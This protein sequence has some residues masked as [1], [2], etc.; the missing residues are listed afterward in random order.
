M[1]AVRTPSD[2]RPRSLAGQV[3]DESG[4]M[5]VFGLY[6]TLIALV[7]GGLALD[8]SNAIRMRTMLQMTADSAAHAAL[9]V[10]ETGT[11]EE[12]Q[13]AALDIVDGIMPRDLYGETV[14]AS[15]IV[16]GEWDEA[17]ATFTADPSSRRAVL[18][19]ANQIAERNNAVD[20]FLLRLAGFDRWSM[21]RQSVFTTYLPNCFREGFVAEDVVD[22]TSGNTYEAGFCIHSN[23][24]VELNNGNVFETGAVVSMPNRNDVVIPA[25][26]MTSNPG[27]PEALR[28][29][30]Y[31]LRIVA[32]INEIIA[33]VADSGSV[34]Y[35]DY[36]DP[37][38]S[39]T[40]NPKN[41]ITAGDW[42]A[43]AIHYLTCKNSKTKVDVPTNTTLRDG[44]LVTNC[45]IKFGQGTI[46]EN[47]VMVTTSTEVDSFSAAQGL[48]LGKDDGCLPGG[49]AQLVTLGGVKVPQGLR[50]FGGQILAAGDVSFTSD[51]GGYEGGSIVSGG[52]I[53]GTTNSVMGACGTTG[54]EENFAAWYFRMAF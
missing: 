44:V 29:G 33:G 4:G 22:V 32:R 2:D 54:M 35:P 41:K 9:L 36:L 17:S 27:L 8:V 25:S 38:P 46:L 5:T 1:A 11:V 53:D 52:R 24:H 31:Y 6:I 42:T 39:V 19:D 51:A 30:S 34:Y 14:L 50:L 37:V 40:L 20:V 18:V 45:T 49:S 12:A 21:L 7:I 23:T 13:A 47:V 15:D 28:D 10:R 16:F 43:G 48:Q 3:A 26:G